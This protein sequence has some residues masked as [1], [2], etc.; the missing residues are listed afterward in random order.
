MRFSTSRVFTMSHNAARFFRGTAGVMAVMASVL[1]VGGPAAAQTNTLHGGDPGTAIVHGDTVPVVAHLSA[2]SFTQPGPF[3]V[4][5][6]TLALPTN[7][8]PVEVWYPATKASVA[9][10]TEATY[11]VVDWLPPALKKLV[12]AGF[13]VTYPSGGVRGVAVAPG[14]FPSFC[15]ATAT[16]GSGTSRP[17]SPRG[18]HPGGSSSR[19]RTTS[20]AT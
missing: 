16:P 20:A 5:E 3:G 8:A 11:D 13:A 2:R 9:N 15:S 10:G 4:G 17:S 6:T 7:G 18:W 19:P 12:P 14:R 1:L